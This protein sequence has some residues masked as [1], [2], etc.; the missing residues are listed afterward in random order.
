MDRILPHVLEDLNITND[1]LPFINNCVTFY[2]RQRLENS[3]K[4]LIYDHNL[5]NQKKQKLLTLRNNPDLVKIINTSLSMIHERE[6]EIDWFF[7]D[8]ND[9]DLYIKYIIGESPFV[10]NCYNLFQIYFPFVFL[11]IY[12]L[13]FVVLK[14]KG[15][16]I[17][18]F[19]YFSVMINEWIRFTNGIFNSIIIDDKLS[20]FF[21]Q[22]T[23]NLY[24]VFQLCKCVQTIKGSIDH[25]IKK[26]HFQHNYQRMKQV[27]RLMDNLVS[28]FGDDKLKM[29]M[30][31]IVAI[32]NTDSFGDELLVKKN[33]H[34]FEKYFYNILDG[35]VG[36]LDLLINCVKLLETSG[37]VLP[38]FVDYNS[39]YLKITKMWN[40]KLKN[41]QVKNNVE[42]DKQQNT[43]ILTGPN[44]SGKSTY[45][46]TALLSILMAQTV[47]I[48]CADE[49][50]LTPFN[51]LYSYINVPDQIGRK[52][53]FECEIDRCYH[54]L[55][56]VN[57]D[58]FVFSVI[59]E[60]FTGTNPIDG[61]SSSYGVCSELKKYRNSI[62]IIST[63]FHY[64]CRLPKKYP[65]RFFNKCFETNY[66]LL[67]GESKQ[68]IG[69][70][71]LSNKGFSKDIVNIAYHTAHKL[72]LNTSKNMKSVFIDTDQSSNNSI[73]SIHGKRK[74][75]S[76]TKTK[77]IT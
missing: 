10:L 26:W 62:Q 30:T 71:L 45:M 21:A 43:M 6:P 74:E 19:N 33:K 59:D 52:S 48:V 65:D 56:M 3:L 51:F 58:K 20:S 70:D 69:I 13:I 17:T 27:V 54:F 24:I 15:I 14:S 63:H 66:N 22:V 35:I 8:N 11:I 5:L 7:N 53:L 67:D 28:K 42:F 32:F 38:I 72:M 9:D 73:L 47:G 55:Q 4:N 16:N 23:V 12:L 64:L 76:E 50:I 49:I 41:D 2:G 29:D 60:L 57:T 34:I 36:E 1:L 75:K 44:T 18:L 37:Y 31:F 61:I 25:F 77:T 68:C 40:P 46:K 39:P